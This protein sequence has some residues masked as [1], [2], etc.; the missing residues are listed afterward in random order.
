[1]INMF[2]LGL[3]IGFIIGAILSILLYAAI[4]LGKN[5]EN[6]KKEK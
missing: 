5:C 3:S 4:L 6:I 1:M 2:W